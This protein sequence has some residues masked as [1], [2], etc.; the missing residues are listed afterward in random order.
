[1]IAFGIIGLIIAAAAIWLKDEKR[2]DILFV[3]AGLFLFVY[4]IHIGD[5]IF[6]ILQII[7]I[8]SALTELIKLG[9]RGKNKVAL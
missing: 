8:A 3:A 9:K 7:F 2:Q 4:S 6:S 1:M 5:E